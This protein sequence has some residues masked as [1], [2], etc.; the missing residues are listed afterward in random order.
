V[1]PIA[2]AGSLRGTMGNTAS[3]K[4]ASVASSIADSCPSGPRSCYR[5]PRA[6]ICCSGNRDFD[7]SADVSNLWVVHGD[8]GR[9]CRATRRDRFSGGR[10]IAGGGS[11]GAAIGNAAIRPT[12]L[13]PHGANGSIVHSAPKE[14]PPAI[15]PHRTYSGAP[16]LRTLAPR[17]RQPD[18]RINPLTMM[19]STAKSTA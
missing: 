1:C 10:V 7:A 5:H 12:M 2:G 11:G 3:D 6:R 4:N 16:G 17:S 15:T 13:T 9:T 8:S 18:Q 14:P 19:L